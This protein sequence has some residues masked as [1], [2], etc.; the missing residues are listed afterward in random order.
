MSKD[1]NIV[2]SKGELFNFVNSEV[3]FVT[4]PTDI[5]WINTGAITLTSVTM[6]GYL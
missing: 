6:H 2:V 1:T 3:N 4:I 5:W